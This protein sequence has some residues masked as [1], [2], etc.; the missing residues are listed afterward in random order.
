MLGQ[1]NSQEMPTELILKYELSVTK[2]VF[3]EDK[4][5]QG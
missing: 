2:G 4:K 5:A 1:D 3:I